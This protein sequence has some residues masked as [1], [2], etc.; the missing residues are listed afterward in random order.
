MLY[1]RRSHVGEG[2]VIGELAEA[3]PA[4]LRSIVGQRHDLGRAGAR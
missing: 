3:E 1:F 4:C 2:K